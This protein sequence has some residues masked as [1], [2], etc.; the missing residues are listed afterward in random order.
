MKTESCTLKIPTISIHLADPLYKD[1]E[2]TLLR[3]ACELVGFFY[4]QVRDDELHDLLG[5][6]FHQSKQFFALPLNVKKQFSDP[7]LNRGYTAMGEETLDPSRQTVGDTKEG[8]Y[9]ADDISKEDPRFNPQK[10]AG[11]NIYPTSIH[12]Q[13]ANGTDSGDD[14]GNV[15]DCE[16]W[17]DS[18]MK[19]H[20]KMKAVCF[21]LTQMLALALH[22]PPTYFDPHFQEPLAVLRLLHYS[23]EVSDIDKGVFAC[24]AHSDYGMLT[25]LAMDKPG[26]QIYHDETWMDVPMPKPMPSSHANT[27]SV[28]GTMTT[29]FVVNLGDML[30][31]WTNGKF[32]STLHRVLIS[33]EIGRDGDSNGDGNDGEIYDDRYSIPFF[34]EPNF[35]TVVECIDSCL[36]EEGAKYP[37][38]TSGQHLLDKYK[39]T[40]ADFDQSK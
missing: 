1:K 34:Y 36:G 4:L 20:E 17:K 3:E 25:A 32:K 18:M 26:L 23:N 9:L 37:P 2:V 33:S 30:E 14:T 7:L 40:H 24:G 27:M 39:E 22:L 21:Q 10:L 31:R 29:T 15:L 16:Y 19:Y 5:R 6:V 38:T 12:T 35:D 13:N 28:T 8:Y 11:P